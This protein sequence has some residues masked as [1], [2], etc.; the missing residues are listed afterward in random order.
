MVYLTLDVCVYFK[1]NVTKYAYNPY[2]MKV[3]T[4]EKIATNFFLVHFMNTNG[5][6]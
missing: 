2:I 3:P 1:I 5:G 6:Q 4:Y